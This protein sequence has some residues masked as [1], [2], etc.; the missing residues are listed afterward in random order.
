MTLTDFA[1]TACATHD[2]ELF[3]PGENAPPSHAADALAVCETCPA[4]A[5]CLDLAM[6]SEASSHRHGIYGGTTPQERA[7]MAAQAE[8]ESVTRRC[9]ECGRHKPLT[10]YRAGRR[11][12]RDCY[13]RRDRAKRAARYATMKETR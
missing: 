13:R 2:P 1:G 4:R 5:A 9:L 7:M 8:K 10:E 11:V 3:F 6:T 12:C